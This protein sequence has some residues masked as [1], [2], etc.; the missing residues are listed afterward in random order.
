MTASN[1]VTNAFGDTVTLQL[2][3]TGFPGAGAPFLDFDLEFWWPSGIEDSGLGDTFAEQLGL[4]PGALDLGSAP[5]FGR[6]RFEDGEDF[7]EVI[8]P[9]PGGGAI[10]AA[11]LAALAGLHSRR[12][13][14]RSRA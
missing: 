11:A 13:I 10:A 3:G 14:A 5:F 12:K 8:V 1:L 2:R 4:A 9:E 7:F 6:I